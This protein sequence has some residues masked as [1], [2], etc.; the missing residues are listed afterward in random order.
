MSIRLFFLALNLSFL[1]LICEPVAIA[2][3][4]GGGA[5][6]L[7]IHRSGRTVERVVQN[8]FFVKQERFQVAPVLGYVPNNPFAKRYV[9][10]ILVSYHYNEE[11]AFEGSITY[12]PDLGIISVSTFP[13]AISAEPPT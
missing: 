3:E 13:P 4:T 5:S 9:G 7:E 2:A 12:S 10:G 6:A 8:R 1:W 11:M